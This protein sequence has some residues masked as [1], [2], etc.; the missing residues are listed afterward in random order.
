M[1]PVAAQLQNASMEALSV[2][3]VLEIDA[4]CLDELDARVSE[5]AHAVRIHVD[6]LKKAFPGFMC[7][8]GGCPRWS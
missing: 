4:N 5:Y 7:E 3:S 1:S 6:Q 8:N 2:A